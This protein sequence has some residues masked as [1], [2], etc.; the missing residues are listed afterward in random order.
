MVIPLSEPKG[1]WSL[2]W[3]WLTVKSKCFGFDI[4]VKLTLPWTLRNAKFK[5]LGFDMFARLALLWTWQTARSKCRACY[6]TKLKKHLGV[7]DAYYEM[8]CK[9]ENIMFSLE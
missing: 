1:E 7:V 9:I 8:C 3:T 4:F 2:F 5:C 6:T